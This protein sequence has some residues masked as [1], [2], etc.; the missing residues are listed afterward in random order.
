M[1]LFHLAKNFAVT[2]RESANDGSDFSNPDADFRV[3]YLGEDGLLHVKDSAGTVTDPY[4]LGAALNLASNRVT[5]TGIG[6]D[7]TTTSSTWAD[8]DSTNLTITMTTGAR[9]VMLTVTGMLS[10]DVAAT[11]VGVGFSVDATGV[12]T[13]A[14]ASTGVWATH[15]STGIFYPISAVYITD[16]LSAA[17]HTFRPRWNRRSGSGTVTAEQGSNQFI[18]FSAVELLAD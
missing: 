9:R 3:V 14:A 8:M 5:R 1:G 11:S 4:A 10:T 18:I 7:L 13:E 15:M 6:S 16:V 2:L 12:P 17:S